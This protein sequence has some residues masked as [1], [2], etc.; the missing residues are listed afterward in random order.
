MY[1]HPETLHKWLRQETQNYHGRGGGMVERLRQQ[2]KK[3][4]LP[5]RGMEKKSEKQEEEHTSMIDER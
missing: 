4:G 1:V 3:E 5:I 2:L